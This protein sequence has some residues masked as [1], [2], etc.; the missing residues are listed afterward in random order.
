LAGSMND[1]FPRICTKTNG[2]IDRCCCHCFGRRNIGAG[3]VARTA[4]SA[5]R[6]DHASRHMRPQP[7]TNRWSLH[8]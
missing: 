1:A 8:V 4:L 6:H 7:K 5:G 3:N 2:Q